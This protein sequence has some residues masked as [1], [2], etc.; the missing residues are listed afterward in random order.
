MNRIACAAVAVGTRAADRTSRRSSTR[1]RTQIAVLIS[2]LIG[3]GVWGVRDAEAGV[4]RSFEPVRKTQRALVFQLQGIDALSI[5]SARAK[6]RLSQRQFRR[7]LEPRYRGGS[8]AK[9]RARRRARR[10]LKP[11]LSPNRV[12]DAAARGVGLR[13]RRPRFV[14]GGRL[15]ITLTEPAAPASAC[16][17]VPS[18]LTAPGCTVLSEDTASNPDPTP[19]WGRIDCASDS[20]H[21]QVTG[22]SD[23]H[24][25]A[26]GT[27]Q[28]DDAFRRLTV[29]DGDDVWG[30]RCELGRNEHRYGEEGGAGTFALF[31][32]GQRSITFASYRLPDSFPLGTTA[33]QPVL[34]M[35]QAQPSA[36][37]GG[38]PILSMNA[39]DGHWRL[40]NSDSAGPSSDSHEIW[41]AVAQSGVWT[42][43]AFDVVHSQDPAQGSITVY[44]DLNGD[45]DATDSGEQSPMLHTSTLKY[46]TLGGSS[47][48]RIAPGASIVS[49]LRSG[50][51]HEGSIPCPTG[52][53]IE[54]DNVQVVR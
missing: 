16:L 17:V 37:G 13:L 21:Q 42:R 23:P 51:Y 28:G 43:F 50:I 5:V 9:R 39:R 26:T 53:A 25:T 12:R 34:Q 14:R 47:T 32:E 41:S 40:M 30:E 1:A 10:R 36:N 19:L 29:F 48:D 49:H 2:L 35:K 31:P 45:G 3:F 54:L 38:T 44:V 22:G 18:T 27:P 6:L 24:P 46:E 15:R 11:S 52:C 4:T 7:W 8:A 33:F 20:R